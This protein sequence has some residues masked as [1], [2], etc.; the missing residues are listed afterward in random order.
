MVQ[1]PRGEPD[2]EPCAPFAQTTASL[3][4]DYSS[5]LPMPAQI[6]LLNPKQFM[7]VSIDHLKSYV[8]RS[9]RNQVI[10]IKSQ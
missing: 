6:F 10:L 5:A 2:P 4:L 1:G 3:S 9:K 7:S 8:D